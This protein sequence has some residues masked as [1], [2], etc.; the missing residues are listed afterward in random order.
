MTEP[1]TDIEWY[2]R[3][4]ATD[5]RRRVRTLDSLQHALRA[6]INWTHQQ[7]A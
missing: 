4:A 6:A 5:A 2:E 3:K 7:D 1:K